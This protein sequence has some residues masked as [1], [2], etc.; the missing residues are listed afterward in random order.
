MSC[1]A[2]C[3]ARR[4]KQ[5]Q[6]PRRGHDPSMSRPKWDLTHEHLVT[7]PDQGRRHPHTPHGWVTSALTELASRH[8]RFSGMASGWTRNPRP[9]SSDPE[10]RL[11]VVVPHNQKTTDSTPDLCKPWTQRQWPRY[12]DLRGVQWPNKLLC[13]FF[14]AASLTAFIM[15]GLPIKTA[16]YKHVTKE[17]YS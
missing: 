8:H 10:C 4:A 9:R 12:Q 16:Q 7:N 15:N 1:I 11:V 13:Q 3:R 6:G 17:H 2:K 5:M 14:I